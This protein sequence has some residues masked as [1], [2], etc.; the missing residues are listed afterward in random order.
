[1]KGYPVSP[2][3]LVPVKE[4]YFLRKLSSHIKILNLNLLN[5]DLVNYDLKT[6]SKERFIGINKIILIN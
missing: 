6:K 3:A 4:Q 1:M 2:D 5:Y